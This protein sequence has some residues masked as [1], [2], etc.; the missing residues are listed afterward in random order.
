[1]L[2]PA[3]FTE[4]IAR[5]EADFDANKGWIKLAPVINYP[6]DGF[7]KFNLG[8]AVEIIIMFICWWLMLF[9]FPIN[10]IAMI[11]FFI[12]FIIYKIFG[13]IF[14]RRQKAIVLDADES[15]RKMDKRE[16]EY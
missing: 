16:L 14:S 3:E 6:N 12:C 15:L 10:L 7:L 4:F 9:P 2:K 8:S 1:M 11:I 13:R 5:E